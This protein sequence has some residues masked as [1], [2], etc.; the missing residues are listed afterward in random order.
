MSTAVPNLPPPLRDGDRLSREEFLRRWEAMPDLKHAE[1]IDGV[2]HMSSPVLS[3]HDRF[4]SLLHGWLFH[5]ESH[6]PGCASGLE[7]TW[8]MQS[9]AAPQPDLTMRILPEFGGQSRIVSGFFSGAPEL[10]VEISNSSASKDL[11]MKADLYRRNG[12][13]EYLVIAAQDGTPLWREVAQ[14][15]YRKILPRRGDV[16]RSR[17]F[18]GLW[19]N[20]SALARH[21]WP[22]MRS[23]LDEGLASAEHAEFVKQLAS[24]KTR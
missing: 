19:L 17:V 8:L 13:R 2:V 24:S 14:Q 5:Y 18:P 11:G 23:T 15:R 20:I 9:D 12:V 7:G 4:H 1:L 3:T 22:G 16:L 6:T 21:D 10:A